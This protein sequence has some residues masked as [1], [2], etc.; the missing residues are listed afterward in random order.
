MK[1]LLIGIFVLFAFGL[2]YLQSGSKIDG[3]IHESQ[4]QA[5]RTTV[6]DSNSLS[7]HTNENTVNNSNLAANDAQENASTPGAATTVSP[8][9]ASAPGP[10]SGSSR[11]PV[12]AATSIDSKA[13]VTATKPAATVTTKPATPSVSTPLQGANSAVMQQEMLQYVNAERAKAG[14][15]PLTLSSSLSNGA[16]L[17]SKDMAENN[18]FS[19]TSPVYGSPFAMMQRLGISY[20]AAAEN[21]AMNSSVAAAHQA[22][23]NSSGHRANILNAS[24]HKA[25][26]G[27][28]Q[29]GSYLYVTQWFTN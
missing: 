11:A 29:K 12:S 5:S 15:A 3:T 22:F 8:A 27:L 20:T 19:H 7:A 4:K 17:K 23:M 13:A 18:Y 24:Y 28:V 21:I 16:W 2:I 10:S 14:I 1:K 25:G 9:S 6:Q 26:F